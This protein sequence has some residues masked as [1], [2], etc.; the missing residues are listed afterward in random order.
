MLEPVW[1]TEGSA[2]IFPVIRGDCFVGLHPPR[3]DDLLKNERR[4]TAGLI[5]IEAEENEF[6]P[7][8]NFHIGIRMIIYINPMYI[9]A[10]IIVMSP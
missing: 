7:G 5:N 2:A 3:N 9:L 8:G 1:A 10:T 6:A 4:E